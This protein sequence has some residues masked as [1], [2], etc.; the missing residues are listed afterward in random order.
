MN[1]NDY[2]SLKATFEN[3]VTETLD[4]VNQAQDYLMSLSSIDKS[5]DTIGTMLNVAEEKLMQATF[6]NEIGGRRT[7]ERIGSLL[8]SIST[9]DT[10]I[11]QSVLRRGICLEGSSY[12]S[13]MAFAGKDFFRL[14]KQFDN[15]IYNNA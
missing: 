3:F 10:A 8:L 5:I 2:N 4:E 15:C 12:N 9:M 14:S 6:S 11:G 7:C 1:N 13:C